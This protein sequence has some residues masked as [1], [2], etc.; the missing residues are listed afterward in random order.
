MAEIDIFT[1]RNRQ[2][3]DV[4]LTFGKNPVTNDVLA[5]TGADAV[6]RA[7]KTILSTR[8]G[9]VPFLPNFGGRLD[10]LLFEP[11]DPI[12]TA[13]I[14]SEIRAAIETYEPRVTIQTLKITPT[15]DEHQYQVDV[16]FV[17]VNLAD[18]ITLTVF[19]SRLR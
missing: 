7:I 10:G 11:I 3:K 15:P 2:Y 17:L 1:F 18:P 8:A 4:S 13:A 12:T 9:E 19:L 16:T 14:N 6:R 5:V